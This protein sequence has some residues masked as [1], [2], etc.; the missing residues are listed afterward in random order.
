[1]Y[2]FI[3]TYAKPHAARQALALALTVACAALALVNA[4][5]AG[6]LVGEVVLGGRRE[7]LWEIL[8]LM[9]GLT[10][11]KL[12]LR[13]TFQMMLERTSQAILSKLRGEL[14]RHVHGLDHGFID[15]T[16]TGDL[17]ALMTGDLDAIRHF[18]AWVIYQVVENGMIFCIALVMLFGIDWRFALILL[19]V[20]PFIAW[21]AIS[22]SKRVKPT[23][24][25]IREQFAR[26]NTRAQE[27]IAGNRVVKAFAREAHEAERFEAENQAYRDRNLE[28]AA[29]WGTHIPLIEFF[30]GSMMAIIIGAGGF[31]VA[32]GWMGLEE[33]VVF[34]GLIWALTNP[35]RMSG[36]LI[37]DI[38][39]MRA[40]LERVHELATTESAL[41]LPAKPKSLGAARP[42]ISVHGVSFGFG[43]KAILEDISF[44]LPAG[45]TLGLVGPTGSGKT[46]L[47]RLLCRHF[48]PCEGE[49]LLGGI[50]L[51][52]LGLGELRRTVGMAMQDVFLFSD[53]IE[54]NIAFAKPEAG[55]AE[56]EAA[57]REACAHDFIRKL[58]AGYGTIVGERGIGLSGG[59]KQRVALARLFLA[60]P[61]V[62]ILDDTTSAVDA[63]TEASIQASLARLKGR[64]TAVI[65]SHR[66]SS[67]RGADLILV[68]DKG[69]IAQSGR[70]EE[71]AAAP[72]WYGEAWEHQHRA[73]R[74][75][76]HGA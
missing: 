19:S 57:A 71:L 72:G 42:D 9:L 55:T 30:S 59:Q 14:F 61:P 12:I 70:H 8:G 62:M 24:G 15:R 41:P 35:L 33:L 65:I 76:R 47:A 49:I 17:M 37:N 32:E 1:M 44:D 31:F 34:S 39:R 43:G 74:G 4:P 26:L 22:L 54:G 68:L 5:L 46:V 23:F 56:I 73:A 29:I 10:A 52:E 40:S 50:P 58:P 51:P 6:R 21:S 69:R 45:S 60:S 2:R 16:R 28:S 18:F 63:E 11:L 3:W 25:R 38:Q 36:W 48:D 13:F 66:L 64:H 67:V 7:L 53:S 20:T 75:V 27:A